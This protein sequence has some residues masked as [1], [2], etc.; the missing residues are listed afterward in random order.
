MCDQGTERAS[1]PVN[2]EQNDRTRATQIR[3]EIKIA[4]SRPAKTSGAA[5]R[6]ENLHGLNIKYHFCVCMEARKSMIL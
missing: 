1:G 6:L 4:P 5:K 2:E 3:K